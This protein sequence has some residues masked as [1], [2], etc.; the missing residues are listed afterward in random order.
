MR[1]VCGSRHGL[2]IGESCDLLI[3]SGFV[4]TLDELPFSNWKASP[5][6]DVRRPQFAAAACDQR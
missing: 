1:A 5:T 2:G 3:T 4:R 6:V